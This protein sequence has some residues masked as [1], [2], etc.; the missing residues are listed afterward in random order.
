[1]M[2]IPYR[3]INIRTENEDQPMRFCKPIALLP[4]LA[5]LALGCDSSS[6][7]KA[8]G[9]VVKGGQPY[10]TGEGQGLRIIFA[11]LDPPAGTRYDSFAAAYDP[12]DGSFEVLG[13]D[14]RG[15][16]PGKYRISLQL[17]SKKEDLW[18]G[19]LTGKKSPFTCEVTPNTDRVVIDLDQA[20]LDAAAAGGR[21]SKNP[22]R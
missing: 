1:M 6:Y 18:G 2:A 15:L 19:Q 4:F 5:L 10:R 9:S 3:L 13:K 7:I 17:I 14:G 11:P 12:S 20:H 16:P 21:M 8:K 22:K